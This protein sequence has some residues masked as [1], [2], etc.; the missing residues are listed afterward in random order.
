MAVALPL[1][2][3]LMPNDLVDHPL[4]HALALDYL[5]HHLPPNLI[6]LDML[7]SRPGY[8]GWRF[9]ARHRLV[10]ALAA[11]PVVITT[12]LGIAS[13]EWARSLGATGLLKKPFDP[14]TLLAE[15]RRCLRQDGPSP[16]LNAPAGS[17]QASPSGTNTKSAG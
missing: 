8:D 2:L 14:D 9:L 4:I 13:D 6:L 1:L 10:P 16:R 12:A 7:L 17:R 3:G 15:V 11:I 5:F